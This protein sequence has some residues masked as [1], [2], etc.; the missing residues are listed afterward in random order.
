MTAFSPVQVTAPALEIRL[1]S[2]GNAYTYKGYITDNNQT[3]NKYSLLQN[4]VYQVLAIL[5][6]NSK[7]R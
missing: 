4:N 3:I 7:I 1:N 6:I 5:D 2:G